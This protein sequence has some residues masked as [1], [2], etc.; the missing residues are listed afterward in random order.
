MRLQGAGFVINFLSLFSFQRKEL[1]PKVFDE[2]LPRFADQDGNYTTVYR[3]QSEALPRY[4]YKNLLYRKDGNLVVELNGNSLPP[5]MP[6]KEEMEELTLRY[7]DNKKN[8]LDD[9]ERGSTL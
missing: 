1:I 3:V 2:F 9:L 4:H 7:F 6:S 5:L 8:E